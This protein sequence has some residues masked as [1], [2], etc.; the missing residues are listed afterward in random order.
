MMLNEC[1]TH[2][3]LTKADCYKACRP[4]VDYFDKLSEQLTKYE[5]EEAQYLLN[6]IMNIHNRSTAYV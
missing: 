5:V 6:N 2:S 4:C 3:A 1:G